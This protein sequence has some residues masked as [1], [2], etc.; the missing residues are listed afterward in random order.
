MI[1]M[2]KWQ[3]SLR[4]LNIYTTVLII[5]VVFLM[6]PFFSSL[7]TSLKPTEEVRTI[8]VR[9]FPNRI[10][11]RN[12]ID[13]WTVV[14]LARYFL[15]SLLISLAGTLLCMSCA[16]LCSYALARFSF[17]GRRAFLYVIL[18]TQMFSPIIIIISLFKLFVAYNLLNTYFALI[19]SNAAFTL[20]LSV[21]LL[22]GY[23]KSI[24]VEIEEASKIDG[25]DRLKALLAVVLPVARPGVVTATIFCFI[26]I[27]NEFM[28][29]LTFISKKNMRPITVGI[30]SFMGKYHI[31]W[32]LLMTS[33]LL[34]TIPVVIFFLLI[35]K[36]LTKGLTAGAI[37]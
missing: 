35:Q 7:M 22:T 8:P 11:L 32:N 26:E 25:C 34:A 1:V 2:S 15:N 28:F 10:Q 19:I 20:A 27:W 5:I 24:P 33:A 18:V 14:P 16:V 3:K 4:H 6:F 21:W 30:Y 13:V 9:L 31:E 37:K 29:A 17:P 36:N 12:Y 23:F